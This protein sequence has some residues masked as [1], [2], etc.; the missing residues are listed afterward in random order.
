MRSSVLTIFKKELARFFGDRRLMVG[1]LMPGILIYIMYSFMGEAMGNMYSV[2]ENYVPAVYV[3]NL[4]ESVAAM[5]EAAG[6][7]LFSVEESQLDDLKAQVEA[8]NKDLVAVFPADFDAAVWAYDTASGMAAPQ[9]EL[10][11]NSASTTSQSTYSTMAAI[12]DVYESQM[13]NKFDINAGADKY[14]LVTDEDMAGMVFSSMLPMLLMMFLY[15][16]CA[17]VAPESIAG[18]KERG[19]IATML[20]T[21]TKRSDIAI[22]K[23]FALAIIALLSGTSSAVGTMLSIPKLMGGVMDGMNANVYGVKDYLLLAAV[24]L[25]TVLLLVTVIS[26]LSAYAKTVKEAQTYGTPVMLAV[27]LTGAS[28][29]FGGGASTELLHYCIPI[30]NS[31]QCMTGIFSFSLM[32]TG[33]AVTVAVN[34][35]LTIFGI[36]VLAKMFN[37]EKIVFSK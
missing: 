20:I 29:M 23:I 9:V 1:I 4:P 37:S 27:T 3:V 12:L 31:V 8:Q 13:A 30:Y 2:D 32:T 34:G 14:D 17:S 15:S 33:V 21:P 18:E 10:Y 25:S 22:G 28:A 11:Y 19:T 36:F 26:L 16:G 5:A 7:E 35:A 24:I 6:M